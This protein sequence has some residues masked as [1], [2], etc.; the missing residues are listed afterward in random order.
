M[1]ALPAPNPPPPPP[2]ADESSLDLATP[3]PLEF[4]TQDYIHESNRDLLKREQMRWRLL[5]PIERIKLRMFV[6]G[7][8]KELRKSKYN[9]MVIRLNLLKRHF[10]RARAQYLATTFINDEARAASREPIQ[11]ILD[12][13][14]IVRSRLDELQET[15]ELYNHY[16]GWL[17]YERKHRRE[18]QRETER[19]KRIRKRMR[20]E[21]K[22]LEDLLLDVF[23][24]TPGCHHI[25]MVDGQEVTSIP[26]FER[27]VVMPD[28]HYFYLAASKRKLTG[29]RWKLPYSVTI[30]R[31][32]EKDVLE[33]MRAATKR[34]VD[35]VWTEAGQMMYRVSRLD[36]PDALPKKVHWRDAMKYFP[37]DRVAKMPYVIGATEGRKFHWFDFASDPHMLV[38][39]KSQSGKSNFV[40][41]VIASLVS[42]HTPAELRL[43]L[44]DQKGGVE[45]THWKEI[46]HLLWEMVKT[47]DQ[48]EPILNRI[49]AI[50]KRRMSLFEAVKAKDIWAYNSK[51][52]VE[53]RM[54]QVFVVIDEM[55]TFVGLGA[56][57]ERIHNLIMLLVSQGRAAG[58][59]VIACT[60]HPEVKV[61]PG[62]IK[63]NM[64]IRACGAMPTVTSSMIVLD[65]PEAA[66]IPSVPGR[67]VI[68]VGLQTL[69][70][71]TPY[72]GDDD[73]AGIVSA[74]RRRYPDVAND[75]VDM[76][77]MP[78]LQTWDEQ[79]VLAACIEWLEGHLGAQKLHEMLGDES[80]GERHLA[81]MVRRLR[82]EAEQIGELVLAKDQTRWGVVKR[83]KG[84]YLQSRSDRSDE[85]P[86]IASPA[87]VS[88]QESE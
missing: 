50:M 83:G 51:V 26:K 56:Q 86:I 57:T 82:D 70:V 55:N 81:K 65:N 80:P 84:Y 21:A 16:Q 44:I 8:A 2:Q 22:W 60:Q 5:G 54:E 45:F 87:I 35:V 40:N 59:H 24:K 29:W 30:P 17:D 67:F 37:R 15:H 49:V 41:G 20:K 14:R 66:R 47:V 31:L 69:I 64:S 77:G 52:D 39:G 85:K 27:K 48:V 23:R 13:A 72:I 61:I 4:F 18:L 3:E 12:E 33:N 34:K 25:K 53:N 38:A 36:S 88:V 19:E 74:C 63:T 32:Q 58:V 6:A 10:F 68:V 9:E 76:R 71:Q 46:P 7:L 28:A 43:V 79:R 1:A 78:A 11:A 75:L 62:R 42:T 73:I